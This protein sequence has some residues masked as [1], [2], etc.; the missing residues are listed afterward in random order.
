MD[1]WAGIDTRPH[2]LNKYIYTEGDPINNI[3]PSGNFLTS[4]GAANTIRSILAATATQLP[5][6]GFHS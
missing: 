6:L 3:D 2:S 1:T 4:L 5:R